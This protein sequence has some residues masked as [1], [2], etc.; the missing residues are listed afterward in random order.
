MISRECRNW[1][2]M[3][4]NVEDLISS[5]S[6]HEAWQTIFAG[7]DGGLRYA[8]IPSPFRNQKYM[9]STHP[10]KIRQR[11][12]GSTK[13]V[14]YSS[15]ALECDSNASRLIVLKHFF[16]HLYERV[17]SPRRSR[18]LSRLNEVRC[19]FHMAQ[20]SLQRVLGCK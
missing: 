2:L 9:D 12:I 11:S 16:E 18:N 3:Y 17:L 5:N 19:R 6:S 10:Q 14:R 15:T 4:L 13:R 8:T 7:N 20:T 1:L